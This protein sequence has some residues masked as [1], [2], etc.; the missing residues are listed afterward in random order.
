MVGLFPNLT[1]AYDNIGRC[2]RHKLVGE[3]GMNVI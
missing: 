2:P 1:R 3:V